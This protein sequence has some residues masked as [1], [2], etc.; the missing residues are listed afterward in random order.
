[1]KHTRYQRVPERGRR[2]L[3]RSRIRDSLNVYCASFIIGAFSDVVG[4]VCLA[5]RMAVCMA[6]RMAVCMASSDV[7]RC[8]VF[9]SPSPTP[10]STFFSIV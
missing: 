4:S 10:P 3:P 8:T 1:M 7:P 9:I 5:H 2:P 6:H